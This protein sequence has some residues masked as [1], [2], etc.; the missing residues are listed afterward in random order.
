LGSGKITEE[1]FLGT[2]DMDEEGVG[3]DHFATVK[4]SMDEI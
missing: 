4:V 2:E 1:L 3:E